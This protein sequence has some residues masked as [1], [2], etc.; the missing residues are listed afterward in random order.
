MATLND[1]EK[2]VSSDSEVIGHTKREVEL[3]EPIEENR[4]FLGQIE[5]RIAGFLVYHKYFF[6]SST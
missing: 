4:C 1:L 5:G 2:L 3:R 6:F